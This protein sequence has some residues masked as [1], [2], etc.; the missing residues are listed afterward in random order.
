MKIVRNNE[1]CFDDL[2]ILTNETFTC[3][4]AKLIFR[5]VLGSY[6]MDFLTVL[7]NNAYPTPFTNNPILP[8]LLIS[9]AKQ[10][11]APKTSETFDNEYDYVIGKSLIILQ[12]LCFEAT[13]VCY[14]FFV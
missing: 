11:H 13:Y 7:S 2:R 10:R 9:L 12:V 4:S 6:R 14:L 3:E 1:I 8:L 5:Y